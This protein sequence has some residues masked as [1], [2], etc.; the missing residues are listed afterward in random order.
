MD[1][2]GFE[3]YHQIADID[4]DIDQQQVGAPPAAQHGHGLGGRFGVCHRCA[5]V[6]GDLGGG[7]ELTLEGSDNQEAHFPAPLVFSGLAR[8]RAVFV[9]IFTVSPDPP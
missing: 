2:F 8:V 9:V 1:V 7:G 4:S 5:L 3:P 6:H